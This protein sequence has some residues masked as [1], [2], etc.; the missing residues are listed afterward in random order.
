MSYRA[1]A[2]PSLLEWEEHRFPPAFIYPFSQTYGIGDIHGRL[3]ELLRLM[4][5]VEREI[6]NDPDTLYP[7]LV[8]LGDY[9]DRGPQT[10]EVIAYLLHD[11]PS[12]GETRFLRGNHDEAINRLL[13]SG[14]SDS[15]KEWAW[16]T[17]TPPSAG[18]EATLRS[19]GV[20]LRKSDFPLHNLP[21][22]R[23][24]NLC[25]ELHDKMPPS[26][27]AFFWQTEPYVV[28]GGSIFVHAGVRPDTPYYNQ[29]G[30][31]LYN[32]REDFLT[33]RG[34]F[35]GKTV[36][37]GHTAS[38]SGMPHVDIN[39]IGVDAGCSFN[40]GRLAAVVIKP[41]QSPRF[42]FSRPMPRSLWQRFK[43]RLTHEPHEE[44]SNWY[45]YQY[46]KAIKTLGF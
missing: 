10:K 15:T 13:D 24:L 18:G 5:R 14:L 45:G 36:I 17:W 40:D 43:K 19:Y 30:D 27:R 2:W 1:P 9:G 20:R 26:H 46:Q 12:V 38:R 16:R 7:I 42:L 41:K 8:F 37:Y 44:S 3:D 34:D 6:C 21:K 39:K 29:Y 33:Y 25:A 35:H 32:I 23:L 31:S 11:L 22:A 28:R 4:D